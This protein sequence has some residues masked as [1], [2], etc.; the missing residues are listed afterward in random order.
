MFEK[1]FSKKLKFIENK[2]TEKKVAL[3]EECVR[4]KI[5]YKIELIITSKDRKM[6]NS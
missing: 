5:L 4:Q 3:I 1:A 6:K 2:N